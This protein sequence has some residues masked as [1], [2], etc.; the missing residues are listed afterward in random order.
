MKLEIMRP[1][2][3]CSEKAVLR[4]ANVQHVAQVADLLGKE[5]A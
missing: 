5:P 4:D 2:E 3:A 1:E